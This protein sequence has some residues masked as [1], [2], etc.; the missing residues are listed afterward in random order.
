MKLEQLNKI[1]AIL[2]ELQNLTATLKS[3]MIN[4]STAL[5]V[6]RETTENTLLPPLNTEE[7]LNKTR[8]QI[9]DAARKLAIVALGPRE[10]LLR[11]TF[12][13][14]IAQNNPHDILC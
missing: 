7:L 3:N 13:V 6:D 10:T 8:Y 14:C 2:N 11:Y 1:S 12:E 5:Q 4:G 9:A